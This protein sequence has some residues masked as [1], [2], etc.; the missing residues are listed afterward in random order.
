MSRE[1][2]EELVKS[3]AFRWIPGMLARCA[4]N[5]HGPARIESLDGVEYG[6]TVRP[7][8]DGP[9]FVSPHDWVEIGTF[10]RDTSLPDLND[11]ATVGCLLALLDEATGGCWRVVETPVDGNIWRQVEFYAPPEA[12][13]VM[14]ATP[15]AALA[16]ALIALG[17]EG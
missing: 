7:G 1:L 8:Q 11:P 12:C 16:H 14:G 6:L 17:G 3:P 9:T 15:G 2:S 5:F 4:R 10:P 13:A